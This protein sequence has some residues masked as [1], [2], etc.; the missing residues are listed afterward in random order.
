MGQKEKHGGWSGDHRNVALTRLLDHSIIH[1]II[2]KDS[3]W[4]PLSRK[5]NLPH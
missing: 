5:R 4:S 3:M 2:L 1:Y